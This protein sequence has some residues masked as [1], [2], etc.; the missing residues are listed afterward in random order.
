MGRGPEG[1]VEDLQG[2]NGGEDRGGEG[3][4]DEEGAGE[5]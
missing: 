4:E 5:R 2:G 3:D 1:G